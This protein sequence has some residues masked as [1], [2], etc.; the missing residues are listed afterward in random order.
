MAFDLKPG[1]F[2]ASFL[3]VPVGLRFWDLAE[4]HC[5][6]H[7]SQMLCR[8]IF[9]MDKQSKTDSSIKRNRKF[10]IFPQKF[11]FSQQQTKIH[12][13]IKKWS[14][15]HRD[16]RKCVPGS[17]ILCLGPLGWAK[18]NACLKPKFVPIRLIRKLTQLTAFNSHRSHNF[19]Q[20]IY[21][22][23]LQSRDGSAFAR[24]YMKAVTTV[25]TPI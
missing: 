16:D 14:T 3:C 11:I 17:K 2:I 22:G 8:F 10:A 23:G 9:H 25:T 20:K 24:R 1:V 5:A 7:F 18:K 12:D 15:E 6:R 4:T 13:L 21:R 19:F